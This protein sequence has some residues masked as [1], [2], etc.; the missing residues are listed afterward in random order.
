MLAKN[1]NKALGDDACLP[2][3]MDSYLAEEVGRVLDVGSGVPILLSVGAAIRWPILAHNG[4]STRLL[5]ISPSFTVT[6]ANHD[7]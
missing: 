5:Q 6:A 2:L 1:T 7:I 4:C 3:D